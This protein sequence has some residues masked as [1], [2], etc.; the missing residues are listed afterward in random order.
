MVR[1][2]VHLTEEQAAAVKQL[3]AEQGVSMSALIRRGVDHVLR[4][5]TR[6]SR[7]E[8]RERAMRFAGRFSAPPDLGVRHDD[9]LAEVFEDEHVRGHQRDPDGGG[10]G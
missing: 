1:T 7:Q 6:P 10:S 4:E 8:L 5:C 9:Y 2:K 3:A